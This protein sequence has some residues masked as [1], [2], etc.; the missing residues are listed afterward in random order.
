MRIIGAAEEFWRLRLTRVDTTDELDFEW[1]EDILY[2]EPRVRRPGEMESWFVEAVRIDDLDTVV[3]LQTFDSR[4]EAE[5]YFAH[6]KEDLSELT[7]NAFEDRYFSVA[8]E[9]DA[10]AEA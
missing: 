8:P 6:A 9:G 10:E 1:H 3:R 4:E 5:A 2:R 7:K